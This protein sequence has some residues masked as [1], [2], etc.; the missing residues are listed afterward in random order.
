MDN[1]KPKAN[2]TVR[3]KRG[4]L[5]PE[6][7]ASKD[8]RSPGTA[9]DSIQTAS[10]PHFHALL[11]PQGLVLAAHGAESAHSTSGS[12]GLVGRFIWQAAWLRTDP[13][14]RNAFRD[15][16]QRTQSGAIAA[17][18][19][20]IVASSGNGGTATLSFEPLSDEQGVVTHIV[21][22][23]RDGTHAPGNGKLQA[24][25]H[26]SR[27]VLDSSPDCIAWLDAEG[28]IR[29]INSAGRKSLEFE[30]SAQWEGKPWW[31]LWPAAEVPAVKESVRQALLGH[32]ARFRSHSLTA[33]GQLKWWDVTVSPISSDSTELAGLR[34]LTVARDITDERVA[35]VAR[36]KLAAIVHSSFDA[37][38]SKD[39]NGIINSWNEAAE[40]V[41][42]YTADEAIGQSVMMLLPENRRDEEVR[43]MER[44]HRGERVEPYDTRRRHKNGSLIDISVTVS[45]VLDAAG[46]IVGASK[47]ARDISDRKTSEAALQESESRMRLA[48]DATG[49]GIWE[50]HLP[51]KIIRWDKQLFQIYG[52]EPTPHGIID[53]DAWRET[54][55]PEDLPHSEAVLQ[56]LI[57]RG[58]RSTREFRIRRR[59]NGQLRHI[60][61][62]ETVRTDVD[63]QT[64]WVIGTN[65]DVTERMQMQ[66]ALTTADRRKDEFL[67]TLAH[68]LR[69]PLAPIRMGLEVL[70]RADSDSAAIERIRTMIDRQLSQLVRLV[71]D[72]MDVSRISS[73]RLDLRKAA[74][75]INTV[76]QSALESAGPLIESMEHRLNYVRASEPLTVYADPTRL[77][78]VFINV[79]NN[80]AKYTERGG[81]IDLTVQRHEQQVVVTVRDSGVGLTAEALPHI[82][83]MFTQVKSTT[84]MAQ[85]GLGIG[86][87]L[88]KRLVEMHGGQVTARSEG[89]GHG[90]EISVRLPLYESGTTD[91]TTMESRPDLA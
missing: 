79:L 89:T 26:F 23:R 86:L 43:I 75:P 76:L 47:I 28:E 38:V 53:Y 60:H 51:S 35:E 13:G 49:V 81:Q 29:F 71:D 82:F 40:R 50:W 31:G 69:N 15:A 61:A 33:K 32:T 73:G 72:L 74:V 6:R 8:Q 44:I 1:A 30:D 45:P 84:E 70:K 78:Q 56:D 20:G 12:E 91:E 54:V 41:F 10:G 34:I 64:E 11:T 85:G 22:S 68:E 37:I 65:R 46:R 48:T 39:L 63:G 21:A 57:Q 55:E 52:I 17:L 7:S 42:G 88:V 77:A 67:A 83:D 5:P 58:G 36:G 18:E 80:A 87:S 9:G 25:E 24:R 62:V 27:T 2:K 59:D 66:L 90:T 19:V 4:K 3:T 14:T 16:L